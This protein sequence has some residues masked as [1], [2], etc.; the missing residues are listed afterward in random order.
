[1]LKSVSAMHEISKMIRDVAAKLK[2]LPVNG[3]DEHA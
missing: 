3:P 1:M 2:L